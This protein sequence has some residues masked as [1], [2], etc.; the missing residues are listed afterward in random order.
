MC[1]CVQEAKEGAARHVLERLCD[2]GYMDRFTAL[3]TA[4]VRQPCIEWSTAGAQLQH[5]ALSLPVSGSCAV[6]LSGASS[7]D[8]SPDQSQQ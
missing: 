4:R 2:C 1:V 7:G 6:S 8:G 3:P 5:L